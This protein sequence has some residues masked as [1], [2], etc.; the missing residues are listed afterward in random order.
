[1]DGGTLESCALD[2]LVAQ[3]RATS[4][5]ARRAE[6]VRSTADTLGIS[7]Q[8]LYR[9]LRAAG[10]DSGRATRC[11][12]G[13]RTLDS[14]ALTDIAALLAKGR[15][16]RGQAN[17][18]AT[19]AH[20]IA[21][22]HG[23][24][25]ATV[26]YSTLARNLRE[27]GLSLGHMRAAEPSVARVSA[28]PNHVWF[29]DISVAIQWY[30][31]DESGKRLD[32][33]SDAGARFYE[34]KRDNITASKRVIHRYVCTDHTS[35][36]YYVR[37]YYTAGEAA[38]DVVDFLYRAMAPKALGASFPFRGI[39]KYL[40]MDQGSANKSALVQNLLSKQGLGVE[41]Q[42]HMPK[43]AKASGSV[44]S[45]HNHWQK[46]YE[47]RLANTPAKDLESLNSTCERF[48]ALAVGDVDRKHARHK[49]PPIEVWSTITAEQL[50][51]CPSKDVFFQ[52][53]ATSPRIATVNNYLNIRADGREWQVRGH[54]VVPG[55][56]VKFRLSPW[57]ESGV[58]A[59]DDFDRELACEAITRDAYGFAEQ[60]LRHKWDDADAPG[61]TAPAPA[62]QA[63]AKKVASGEILPPSLDVFAD[64]DERLARRAYLVPQGREWQTP[65]S[66]IA[67]EPVI[68]LF[69][70]RDEVTRRLDRGLTKDEGAWWRARAANGLTATELEAAFVAF[71]VGEVDAST[72][73]GTVAT[74]ARTA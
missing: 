55:Q 12:A 20:R 60:G 31:R 11:D 7:V 41:V 28:H 66:A 64:L 32:L 46:S 29:F 50:R 54:N 30:F 2:Q 74:K 40:V 71:T 34:G 51:E 22:E 65:V 37:Y 53:A 63:L 5:G 35:G 61:A 39:P 9:K 72:D 19:E 58:R 25:A 43:N 45:R 42:L 59:W 70:V 44:E 68:G 62:G 56:K 73:G 67:A 15:N 27:T 23:L 21:K 6:L 10:W 47:G 49:K 14:G 69:E 4:V 24:G 33:Y 48:N 1:M 38:V 57:T 16:K 13:A 52:L 36:A 17:V 3:L 26:A 18:P 8:T